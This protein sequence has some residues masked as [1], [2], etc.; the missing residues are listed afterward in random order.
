[1]TDSMEAIAEAVIQNSF[2]ADIEEAQERGDHELADRLYRK[3]MGVDDPSSTA[4]GVEDAYA[5]Y[6]DGA[7]NASR[8]GPL[9]GFEGDYQDNEI[10]FA[11]VAF[12]WPWGGISR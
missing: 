6:G 2:E 8:Q 5:D 7:I 1:M 4:T 10:W 3:S 12:N 9:V 11:S